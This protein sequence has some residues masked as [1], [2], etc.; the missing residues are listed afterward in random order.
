MLYPVCSIGKLCYDLDNIY[1]GQ[2]YP[3]GL[4]IYIPDDTFRYEPRVRAM[5]TWPDMQDMEDWRCLAVLEEYQPVH[6]LW[7]L[8]I[9]KKINLAGKERAIS[10][11]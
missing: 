8:D 2:P 9:V 5:L 4:A 6:G 1:P 3:A 11:F 7:L 10:I